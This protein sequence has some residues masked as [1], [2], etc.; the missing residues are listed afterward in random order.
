MIVVS[1]ILACATAPWLRGDDP[2]RTETGKAVTVTGRI[3]QLQPDEHQV[4]V[5]TTD[6]KTL[7]LVLDNRSKVQRH[8]QEAKLSQFREGERVRVT[9]E[10][11]PQGNRVVSL[12]AAPMT[13][14]EVSREFRE[15][16]KAAKTYTF[17]QKDEY[18]KRLRPV[19]RDLDDRIKELKAQASQAGEEAR[20]RLE[21]QIAQL[22]Q[23]RQ[24]VE[25]KLEK[26]KAATPAAW[27]E[28]KSGISSAVSDL[29]KAFERA[30]SQF[31][32]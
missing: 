10:P 11:Q 4:K 17:E 32:K 14:A 27:E 25:Q 7:T 23:Q 18:A 29:Q 5:T 12:T 28:I 19:L 30:S 21:P 20:K 24:V 15:A 2:A 3:A 31:S 26:I 13:A 1:A 6:G 16:L 8:Q 22:R 9:Y